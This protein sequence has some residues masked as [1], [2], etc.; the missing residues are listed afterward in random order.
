MASCLYYCLCFKGCSVLHR[1]QTSPRRLRLTTWRQ[2]QPTCCGTSTCGQPS[3][4]AT[5]RTRSMRYAVTKFS[6]APTA[7]FS[8]LCAYN[9]ASYVRLF[10]NL[11]HA[12]LSVA[13][14]CLRCRLTLG[15]KIID[16]LDL[17]IAPSE[18]QTVPSL[19]LHG[20]SGSSVSVVTV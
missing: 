8:T 18:T 20:V 3:H 13:R 6:A 12:F 9:A 2:Q 16:P 1:G 5:R 14:L 15:R 7:D 11:S 10:G 17:L 19:W 4:H